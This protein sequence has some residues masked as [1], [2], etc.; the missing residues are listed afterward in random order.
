MDQMEKG[1]L[2]TPKPQAE[3]ENVLNTHI[4]HIFLS[5][6]ILFLVHLR[7]T[8]FTEHTSFYLDPWHKSFLDL[9]HS[10][11][12]FIGKLQCRARSTFSLF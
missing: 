1:P 4:I 12:K 5:L 7:Q 3:Y 2:V 8:T 9:H 6:I 11:L 10:V